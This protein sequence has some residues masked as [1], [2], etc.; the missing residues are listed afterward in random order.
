MQITLSPHTLSLLQELKKSPT[1]LLKLRIQEI[2][3]KEILKQ[4]EPKKEEEQ[5][6]Y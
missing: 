3:I 4:I 6:W 1:L 2:V 5:I